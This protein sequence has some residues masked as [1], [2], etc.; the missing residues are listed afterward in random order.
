MNQ[1]SR[2]KENIFVFTLR[3]YYHI[4]FTF[5]PFPLLILFINAFTISYSYG[6]ISKQ[7][8]KKEIFRGIIYVF[9]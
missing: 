5:V 6:I 3:D 4:F 2:N 8:R 1:K 7:L 9:L